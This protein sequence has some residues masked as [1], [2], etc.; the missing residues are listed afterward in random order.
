MA[1]VSDQTIEIF[2][3][4]PE[5]LTEQELDLVLDL[6]DAR[7]EIADYQQ[8][9]NAP[10]GFKTEIVV[11]CERC[12]EEADRCEQCKKIICS[13]CSAKYGGHEYYCIECWKEIEREKGESK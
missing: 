8:K 12:G 2:A 3:H 5:N 11:W 9:M 13:D 7:R 1:R 6:Q 10:E 4:H